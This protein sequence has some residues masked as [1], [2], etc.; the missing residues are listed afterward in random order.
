MTTVSDPKLPGKERSYLSAFLKFLFFIIALIAVLLTILFNM[1]GNSEV[2][3]SSLEKFISET[4]GGRPTTISKLNRISFFPVVGVDFEDLQVKETKA[5][6]DMS[7]SVKKVK[8]FVTFWGMMVKKTEISA[9]YIEDLKLKGSAFGRRDFNVEKLFIDHDKGT[10]K[11]ELKAN[12]SLNDLPWDFT[13]GLEVTGSVGGYRYGFGK[14][15]ELLFTLDKMKL[16]ANVNEQI[17]DYIK[18]D[19]F[20]VSD[21]ETTVSGSLSLSLLEGQQVKVS[22]RLVTGDQKTVMK[23]DFIWDYSIRPSKVSGDIV[24]PVFEEESLKGKKGTMA[25]MDKIYKL[26]IA[27]PE[28]SKTE[29][30][31]KKAS[32]NESVNKAM[33]LCSYDFDLK[34]TNAT[35]A[36][37]QKEKQTPFEFK[38]QNI[39]SHLKIVPVKGSVDAYDGPCGSHPF[40]QP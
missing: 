11:A 32:P 20:S 9:F 1:G 31:D 24:F 29:G 21:E 2:L 8:A 17:N 14:N 15:R 27:G 12:G 26:V 36:E 16:A 40:F 33:Y 19:P 28:A 35:A 39:K 38:A 34:V 25:L 18:I 3:K 37:D 23:P 6:E 10:T 22:G 5:T 4:F 30:K 13:L 7:L